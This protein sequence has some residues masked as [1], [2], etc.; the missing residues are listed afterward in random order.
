MADKPSKITFKYVCPENLRDLH[1]NGLFGGVT[2]RDEIYIHF[3]SER[4]PIPKKSTHEIDEHGVL[5]KEAEMEIGGDVVRLVQASIALD[6]NTA[7]A[8]RDWLNE[9]INY[10]IASKEDAPNGTKP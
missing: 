8:M 5:S 1:I 7:V 10:I 2:P 9:K 3:Y 6:I 4:H